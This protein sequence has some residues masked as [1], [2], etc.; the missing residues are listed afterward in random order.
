MARQKQRETYGN[1]SITPQMR[2]G[3]QM[4]NPE[5]KPSWRICVSLGTQEVKGEDGRT[6]K[7]RMKVQRVF[8]GTIKEARAALKELQQQY[9]DVDVVASREK[10]FDDACEAWVTSMRISGRAA[11]GALDG[12]I[13]NLGHVRRI[14]GKTELAKVTR[15]DVENAL[16]QIR[17]E[18]NLSGTTMHK[19]FAVT[20]RVFTFAVDNYWL[21]R[22]PCATID[23]PKENEVTRRS[24]SEEECATF[25]KRLDEEE[26]K[27]IAEF[28]AKEAR[29]AKSG[30]DGA[31]NYLRGLSD[32]SCIIALR[33]EL[34]TGMRRSE[35]LGLTWDAVD[36]ERGIIMVDQN[37]I[38]GHDLAVEKGCDITIKKT[39]TSAGM[40]QIHVD[41]ATME[42][43]S[44]WKEAQARILPLIKP[45]GNSLKQTDET[46]VCVGDKGSWMRP[47]RI[48]HWW[49]S[50]QREGFRD[51]V[52]FPGLLMHELRHTQAT[53]LLAAG[54]DLKTVQVRMGHSKSSHTLDLYAHAVP[55]ND[56][57]AAQ[58]IGALTQPKPKRK[59]RRR[60]AK[61]VA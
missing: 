54:V 13:R 2:D 52:G 45:G 42:H 34:A 56:E 9:E 35:V 51:K 46:P 40:R 59:P 60:R 25:H 47:N 44:N 48:S 20:K 24:L 30:H 36:F 19:I 38:E 43:L 3:K 8:H 5:G 31:R 14:I 16:A 12:Y 49:G 1:G 22:N 10:T 32:I 28:D 6:Q 53:M 17:T 29:M 18:R 11:S 55:A 58:V 4:R 23:A 37:L 15:L 26:A 61:A 50:T 41:T 7:K 21:V 33:I 27:A 57:A 39:K